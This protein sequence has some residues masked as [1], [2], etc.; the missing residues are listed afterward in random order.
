MGKMIFVLAEHYQGELEEPSLEVLG[1]ARRLAG[2]SGAAVHAVLLGHGVGHLT[3]PLGQCGADHVHWADHPLLEHYSTDGYAHVL[4]DLLRRRDP[5]IF[6]LAAS[7]L[8]RD[9]AP[10]IAARRQTCLITNCTAL[11]FNTDGILALKR[12]TFG[13]R[14]W[15]DYLCPNTRPLIA[16]VRPG[17]LGIPPS[18]KGR[19]FSTEKIQVYLTQDQIRTKVLKSYSVDQ[20]S[21]DI[22]EADTVLALGRGIQDQILLHR[23]K[24]LAGLLK[25]SFGGSRAAVDE[26]WIPY[27]RQIGQS[28]KTIAPKTILCLGISGAPQFTMGI[29]ESKFIV[30][31]N[32]D[33][34]API[35]KVADMAVVGDLREIVPP[36][37]QQIKTRQSTLKG[38]ADVPG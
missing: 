38:T 20:D 27:G 35:F 15:A 13:G 18:E 37:I 21:L 14:A 29:R 36:L 24:E 11:G 28:G 7:P 10:R 1:E 5:E 2:K 33:R 16:T 22:T 32:K 25:A 23:V 9:L 4:T 31:V 17:V 34:Q 12:P 19:T 3:D 30:A 26:G 8:S 6:L